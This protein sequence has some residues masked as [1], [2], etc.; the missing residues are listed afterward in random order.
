MD[1]VN[2]LNFK[3]L[4]FF[5]EFLAAL[6]GIIYY[7]K[8]RDNFSRYFVFFLCFVFVVEL[9]G[10]YT[11]LYKYNYLCFLEATVFRQNHWLYNPY[12]ILNFVFY[13]YFFKYHIKSIKIQKLIK[14]TLVFYFLT[15][16]GYLIFSDSFFEGISAY[17]FIL[18]SFI[19]LLVVFY[20][21]YEVLQD[22]DILNFNRSLPFYVATG[23]LVF[24]LCVCP[25]FIF[26]RYFK[27]I[28]NP[29]FVKIYIITLTIANIFMYTCFIVGLRVCYKKNKSY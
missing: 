22:D 4:I 12:L 16:W 26:S 1:I 13:I 23:A 2:I 6:T 11:S 18:G 29:Q 10:H 19:L 25:L 24:H 28:E 27:E 21:F 5:F 20:Y 3:E 8:Y 9:I 14:Y 7:A 17:T 15:T